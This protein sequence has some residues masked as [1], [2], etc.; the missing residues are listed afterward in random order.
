MLWRDR[1]GYGFERG[2]GRAVAMREGTARPGG[3]RDPSAAP[4]PHR[5]AD[6]R[7]DETRFHDVRN[8]QHLARFVAHETVQVTEQV[9][10]RYC[11]II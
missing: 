3:A 4:A 1:P 6:Y 7:Q 5:V 10:L 8:V 11:H 2:R 9:T